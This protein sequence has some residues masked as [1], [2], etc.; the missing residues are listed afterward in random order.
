M[1]GYRL[2]PAAD[3]KRLQDERDALY[4]DTLRLHR[5]LT[6]LNGQFHSKATMADF[7]TT[8]VNILE[9]ESAQRRQQQTG[10]PTVAPQI[11]RPTAVESAA[12]SAGVDIFEDVGDQEAERLG[13]AG[14]LHDAPPLELPSARD[15]VA[16]VV[17]R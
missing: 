10:L 9:L 13:K 12:L 11:G 1:L 4:A 6:E 5:E 3:L 14:L 17:G 7:L 15:L 16:S 2:I 8:R